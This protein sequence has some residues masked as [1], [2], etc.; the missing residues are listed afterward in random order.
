[1]RKIIVLICLLFIFSS[2]DEREK[3]AVQQVRNINEI[4]LSTQ[5]TEKPLDKDTALKVI[6][7]VCDEVGTKLDPEFEIK[8]VTDAASI[9]ENPKVELTK[10]IKS[11]K[12]G[13]AVNGWLNW[14]TILG[15]GAVAAGMIG[16]FLGPPFNLAGSAIQL[17]AS[18][19]VPNYDKSK[20]ALSGVLASTDKMLSDYGTLLDSMPEVKQKLVE[21][22]NGGD[23]V[24]WMKEKLRKSQVDLGTHD[25]ISQ[26]LSL[27]KNELTT[28][29]GVLH[30]TAKEL[31][32]FISKKI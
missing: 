5:D 8:P 32:E 31:D 24:V 12:A 1:M 21:K 3:Y 11:A 2:C 14:A 19:F 16:R 6:G 20:K 29:D 30:P 26:V 7:I 13:P 9:V 17:V 27:M 10:I 22:L 23:P 4:V 18:K 25:E 15:V 28:K